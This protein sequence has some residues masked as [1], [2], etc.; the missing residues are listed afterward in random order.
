MCRGAA[1]REGERLKL[2]DFKGLSSSKGINYSRDH[3]RRK[4]RAGEFP[5]PIPVSDR[6]IGWIESKIDKWLAD[7]QQQRDAAE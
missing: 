6:R 2:I 5:K 7:K 1:L 4:C 3:L